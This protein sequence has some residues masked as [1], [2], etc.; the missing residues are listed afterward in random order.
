MIKRFKQ[1]IQSSFR[2]SSIFHTIIVVTVL[3]LIFNVV[4]SQIVRHFYEASFLEKGRMMAVS[5]AVSIQQIFENAISDGAI[6][7][8]DL[9]DTNYRPIEGTDPQKYST[10]YDEFADRNIILIED[11]YLSD[12]DISFAVVVDINGYLPT[13][14]SI[15]SNPLSGDY[16]TDLIANRTKRFFNDE[17]GIAAAQNTE[18]YLL[19][20]YERDTGET[21]WDISAPIYVNGKHWGAFRIGLSTNRVI[22]HIRNVTIW[23]TVISIFLGCT[24]LLISYLGLKPIDNIVELSQMA[25]KI[26]YGDISSRSEI[27]RKDE[28]GLLADSL[29]MIVDSEQEFVQAAIKVAEGNLSNNIFPRSDKD[30]LSQAFSKMVENLQESSTSVN[31]E[32]NLLQTLLDNSVDTIYFKDL[33]SKFIRISKSQAVRFGLKNANEAIGKSDFDFFAE[34]HAQPAFDDEQEII[35]TGNPILYKEEEEVWPDR[36]SNWVISTKL[37]LYDENKNVIGTFGVSRDVT[38]KK[39]MEE[40]LYAE[41]EILSTTLMSISEGVIATDN[42]GLI[43]YINKRSEELT[44]FTSIESLDQ[45][46]SSIMKILNRKSE[47][48]NDDVIQLLYAIEKAKKESQRFTNPTLINKCGDKLLLNTSISTIYAKNGQV[49]GHVV[50]FDD[51]TELQETETETALSQKMESIG[52][53]ASGIAHE[54]NTPIQY[55]GD[56]LRYLQRAF[57]KVIEIYKMQKMQIEK[58]TSAQ[59]TVD[60][61][62]PMIDKADLKKVEWYIDEV[63]VSIDDALAGVERVRK[64]VLAMREFSHPSGKDKSFSDI[65]KGIETTVTISRNEWKYVADIDLELEENLPLVNC[66]MDEINQVVLN[67]II[68]GTHAIK[69]V[70]ENNPDEKGKITI[71]TQST[72]KNVTISITDTG[73]GIPENIRD[74]VFDPF[75]TT[76]GVGKGTGQGLFL[77]HNIIINKHRGVIKIESEEGKGTTF[78]IE[79]P[80]EMNGEK[81]NGSGKA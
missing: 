57:T 34:E 21:M 64:I 11:S 26:S 46:L 10:K 66:Y 1:W 75:F 77:A 68:N 30:I 39:K 32:K 74:R 76:K 37:P 51:I 41:K 14:N 28:I 63:P 43:T 3:L 35:R 70:V 72:E 18:P 15:Y 48:I 38:A 8:D 20:V 2:R 44:G 58:I 33:E 61:L 47:Q 78:I 65:N 67:M 25:Q 9:F 49:V 7:E 73:T 19:Q 5:G 27:N 55:V 54:I 52:Q 6:R 56:N 53:M 71:K 69:D 40:L 45:P 16:A 79:I 12:H 42:E 80:I 36:E 59:S 24:L 62:Q 22:D 60:D 31:K 81:N 17:V 13:H 4:V 23:I 50:V 29:N